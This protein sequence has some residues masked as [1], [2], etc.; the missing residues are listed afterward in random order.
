MSQMT[1]SR[2]SRLIFACVL[3]ATLVVYKK[4][5][6]ARANVFFGASDSTFASNTKRTTAQIVDWRAPTFF[7]RLDFKTRIRL[8]EILSSWEGR[9]TF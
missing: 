4:S 3:L 7:Y 5:T 6:V 1:R 2:W 8:C 9:A